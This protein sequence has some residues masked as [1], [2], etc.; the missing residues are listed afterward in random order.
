[1]NHWQILQGDVRDRLAELPAGSVRCC[2]LSANVPS[3]EGEQPE[4]KAA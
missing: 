4:R 3:P 2:V 1:M